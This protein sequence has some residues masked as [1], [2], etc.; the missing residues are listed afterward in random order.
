MTLQRT[1][2][3]GLLSG[4]LL[5]LPVGATPFA[6]NARNDAMGGTGVASA[7]YLA[8]AFYNPALMTRSDASDDVG[9]LLP[10]VGAEL[11]DPDDLRNQADD[12]MDTYDAFTLASY[13]F[14]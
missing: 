12:F 11:F 3:F 4:S 13:N 7:N 5:A 8:A 1:A 14:V 6:F 9:L 10:V 2:L